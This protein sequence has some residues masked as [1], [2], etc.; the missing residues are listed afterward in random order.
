MNRPAPGTDAAHCSP[1]S[2]HEPWG[3][4]GKNN[5]EGTLLS[6][7]NTL[8]QSNLKMASNELPGY[9]SPLCLLLT[10]AQ[11]TRCSDK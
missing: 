8:V 11:L 10:Q 3:W 9:S 2:V 4:T 1:R 6:E 5:L 7:S